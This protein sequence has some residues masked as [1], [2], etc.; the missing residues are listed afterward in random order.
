MPLRE[1]LKRHILFALAVLATA[2]ARLISI[3]DTVCEAPAALWASLA[4]PGDLED[5]ATQVGGKEE[6]AN[7]MASARQRS[8][9]D[10]GDLTA[11]LPDRSGA[12][13]VLGVV[14]LEEAP[15][16]TGLAWSRGKGPPQA[17]PPRTPLEVSAEVERRS[18]FSYLQ[19]FGRWLAGARS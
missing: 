6:A 14:R 13:V 12:P 1:T 7:L 11:Q 9:G 4:P 3:T 16:P 2:P 8:F 15:T 5:V 18:L 10:G 19:P 17:L